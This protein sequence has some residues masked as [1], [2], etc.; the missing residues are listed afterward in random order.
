MR[1]VKTLLDKGEVDYAAVWIWEFYQKSI[2][3]TKDTDASR[4]SLE[5][6]YS[7]SLIALLRRPQ[8]PEEAATP[9]IVLTWPL[10][11]AR[12][13]KP[14]AIE[15]TASDGA[16]PVESVAFFVD[17]KPLG[18]VFTPPYRMTWNPAGAAPHLARLSAVARAKRGTTSTDAV[19]TLVNGAAE[20]CRAPA[21]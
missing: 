4:F 3:E 21:D 12:I 9:R 19:E 5:P 13:D 17:G 10:P 11:C 2:F 15:A 16:I 18:A 7:D 8:T 14:V 20:A 6:G 1:G